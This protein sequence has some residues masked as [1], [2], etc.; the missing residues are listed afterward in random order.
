MVE[1]MYDRKTPWNGLGTN[2]TEA[3]NSA[4]ALRAA[5]LD[6]EVVSQPVYDGNQR[7]IP[8]YKANVRETDGAILGIVRNRYQV[9]QNSEA[10]AFTDELVGGDV[11]YETA[12]ALNGGRRIWILAQM[13]KTKIAGD[14]TVPY[15][16]FSNSHDGSSRIMAC[17]TPVRVICQ[18]TLNLAFRGA[19]RK[20]AARH[21]KRIQENVLEARRCLELADEYMDGLAKYADRL[22][23]KRVTDEQ[24]DTILNELFP[25]DEEKDSK[26]KAENVKHM[27]D[28]FMTAYYMVD[29]RPFLGTA[30][31]LV[32]AASDMAT[33]SN[34]IR[35]TKN[36]RENNWGRVMDGH[37][38][39]DRTVE[40]VNAL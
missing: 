12:G 8:G 34:P 9:V 1:T 14:E 23:N 7:E 6:W 27:K 11:R 31:G 13:P 32:N 29:L 26:R 21:T 17:M 40:L 18:N 22:A 33:H 25:F 19:N 4:Q 24:I 5:G 20:W 38:M 37:A 39:I 36:Y 16:C 10:F 30:W 28:E 15:L 2:V 35:N 3:A